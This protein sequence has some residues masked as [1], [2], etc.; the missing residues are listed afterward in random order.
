VTTTAAIP[1]TSTVAAITADYSD[2]IIEFPNEFY[3]DKEDP[4]PPLYE[5]EASYYDGEI[6]GEALKLYDDLDKFSRLYLE[7]NVEQYEKRNNIWL[8]GGQGYAF[9]LIDIYGNG[10]P[11]V[12]VYSSKGDQGYS[13]ISFFDMYSETP[14]KPFTEENAYGF[15]RDGLTY[16][17]KNS[18]GE[19][20][21]C[22][23]YNHASN[24]GSI[25]F[26]KLSENTADDGFAL[27]CDAFFIASIGSYHALELRCD[28]MF[29]DGKMYGDEFGY[30]D[31]KPEVFYEQ[32]RKNYDAIDFD[33]YW[34]CG[35]ILYYGAEE[36]EYKGKAAY[37]KY[38]EFTKKQ[39]YL[40]EKSKYDDNKILVD[41][42]NS[43][44]KD[45]IIYI[46]DWSATFAYYHDGE[47]KEITAETGWGDGLD[48][49]G[50][51]L[52]YNKET[53][54]FLTFSVASSYKNYSFYEFS[55]GEYT[56]KNEYIWREIIDVWDIDK[57]TEMPNLESYLEITNLTFEDL[58]EL[59]ESEL[60]S[61]AWVIGTFDRVNQ[62]TIDDKEVTE[63]KW[64]MAID[65]FINADDTILLC[66]DN[67]Y[68]KFVDVADF[69]G[70]FADDNTTIVSKN[71]TFTEANPAYETGVAGEAGGGIYYIKNDGNLYYRHFNSWDFTEPD[72][73][74][75]FA[76]ADVRSVYGC[77]INS[78]AQFF[79]KNDNSL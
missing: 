37:E 4:Q 3:T 50:M 46:N 57:W 51:P 78:Y 65:D 70:N 54:E 42:I 5:I 25:D 12:F 35:D 55:D 10:K 17:G 28:Y 20:V 15:C 27:V 34:I 7:N 75:I 30:D 9:G 67:A 68:L 43:D 59:N 19:I 63:T 77:E 11:I 79:I 49:G 24:S 36:T 53:D 26:Y 58:T 1:E 71:Q 69:D 13:A 47:I 23:G 52:Y 44:G 74:E 40:A 32:Y 21:M 61:H 60:L 45:D 31:V 56:L 72:G 8:T 66:P 62:Y 48:G 14:L 29:Y 33:V 39:E 22:S 16:F 64:Q 76:A 41:D 73:E 6:T 38:L 2:M 18:D